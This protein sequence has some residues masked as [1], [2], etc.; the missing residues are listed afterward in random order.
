MEYKN[1]RTD[2]IIFKK[3]QTLE[4]FMDMVHQ[5]VKDI[6]D[7]TVKEDILKISGLGKSECVRSIKVG[8]IEIDEGIEPIIRYC[9][10]HNYET[11]ASCSGLSVD[12]SY[13][14]DHSGY[15]SFKD[16]EQTHLFLDEFW[17]S[18]WSE[19]VLDYTYFIPSIRVDLNPHIIKV[20]KNKIGARDESN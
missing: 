16:T 19:P 2:D 20:L 4:N 13:N 1:S 9:Y 8:E 14:E 10:E 18:S 3:Y 7:E 5:T 6:K 15:I 11:I 17:E 12:H